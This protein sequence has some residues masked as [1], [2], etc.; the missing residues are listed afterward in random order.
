MKALTLWQPWAT[1]VA[2][3]AKRIETRSWV[4]AYRG[5][6]AIH[7]A[8]KLPAKW[9]GSSRHS[10]QFRDYLADIF[11]VRR[12]SDERTGLHVDDAIRALPYG[13]VLCVVELMGVQST[14]NLFEEEITDMEKCFGN[15]EQGRYAWFLNRRHVF[16]PPISAKGNRMLWNWSPHAR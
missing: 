2:M 7:S 3:G 11:N 9:L 6:I 16:E 8:A 13:K 10:P 5:D 4:T 15:Y 14:G 12:D 1:L